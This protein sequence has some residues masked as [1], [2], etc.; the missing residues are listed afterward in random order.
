MYK[1][2]VIV[3]LDDVLNNLNDKCLETL[4]AALGTHLT[5]DDLT[6][7]DIF[8]CLDFEHASA[9]RQL[10]SNETIIRSLTPVKNSQWGMKHF[11]DLGYDVY[12]ATASSA[13]SFAWKHEWIR[14]LYPFIDDSHIM[15]VCDK[16]LLYADVMIDDCA[17]NLIS[18]IHCERVCFNRAWNQYARDEV[19]GIHRCNNWNEIVTTVDNIYKATRS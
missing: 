8:K 6:H 13:S 12:I 15:R 16:S 1:F 7:Y 10:W 11:V 3:D 4:N 19:Y 9:Y 2:S 17:E 18:N 14:S 5:A